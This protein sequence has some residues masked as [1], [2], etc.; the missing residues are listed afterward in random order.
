MKQSV[1]TNALAALL[2]MTLGLAPA[3]LLAQT[4]N[5]AP[6]EKKSSAEKKGT[7]KKGRSIPFTGEVVAIDKTAKTITVDKRTFVVNSEAKI[8]KSDKPAT[9]EEGAVGA[10]VTGSYIKTVEGP[11]VAHSVYFGGKNKG[12]PAEQKKATK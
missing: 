2:I 9:L 11:L 8:F 1:F 5:K 10:Y 6:A 3:Q 7:E 4:T 12:K